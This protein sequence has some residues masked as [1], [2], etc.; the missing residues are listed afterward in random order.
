MG[1]SA[2]AAFGCDVA[3][4]SDDGQPADAQVAAAV[5]RTAEPGV[6]H[7]LW[8]TFARLR[9]EYENGGMVS[10]PA[11]VLAIVRQCAAAGGME[12]SA[13]QV[14]PLAQFFDHI[15]RALFQ[16]QTIAWLADS[17]EFK[18]RLYGAGW[19]EHPTFAA[20][21]RGPIESVEMR[22]AIWRASRINLAMGPYGAISERVLDGIA[23]GGFFLMRFCPADVIERFYPPI[24]EFCQVYGITT[25]S[26]LRSFATRSMRRL[27]G[28]ASRTLGIDVL[29]DWPDF[30]PHVLKI[31]SSGHARSAAALWSSYPAVSFASRDQLLALCTRYLYDTPQRL[32]LAEEMRRQL[33]DHAKR[34]SVSVDRDLLSQLGPVSG[35]DVAA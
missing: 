28:F 31:A 14:L 13:T 12:L 3:L 32:A 10:H 30:V 34:V 21:S 18:I 2:L 23:A 7:L 16:Q 9:G 5:Q 11:R 25:T 6:K 4:I 35:H 20:L 24:A 15:N 17:G 29:G 26:E 33:T 1:E 8:E 19:N 27:L 22:R